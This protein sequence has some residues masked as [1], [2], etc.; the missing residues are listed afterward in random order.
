[1]P[2]LAQRFQGLKALCGL[3]VQI[4]RI[5]VTAIALRASNILISLQLKIFVEELIKMYGCFVY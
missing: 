3:V 2:H 4:T 1:L 5:A